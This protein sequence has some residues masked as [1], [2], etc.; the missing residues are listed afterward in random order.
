MHCDEK[1]LRDIIPTPYG[2]DLVRTMLAKIHIGEAIIFHLQDGTE[3]YAYQASEAKRIL[4]EKF[5]WRGDP[6]S[7]AR[8]PR[9]P[10]SEAFKAKAH[11]HE[12]AGSA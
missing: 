1:T 10:V 5:G 11:R 9:R 8:V 3:L 7:A 4:R 12:A 2:A 6:A